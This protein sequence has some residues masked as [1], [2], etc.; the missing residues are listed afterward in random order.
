[1]AVEPVLRAHAEQ[2]FADELAALAASDLG[3]CQQAAAAARAAVDAGEARAAATAL[4]PGFGE[5]RVRDR[6]GL[7][8]SVH[9]RLDTHTEPLGEPRLVGR[10][11]RDHER[12]PQLVGAVQI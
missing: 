7:R 4:L 5:R 3:Q 11:E 8:L 9:V 1:M 10:R 2:Q 6:T 12:A